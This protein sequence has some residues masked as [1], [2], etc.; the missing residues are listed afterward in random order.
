MGIL[1]RAIVSDDNHVTSLSSDWTDETGAVCSL[2]R[3]DG[4]DSA[5]KTFS[6][7]RVYYTMDSTKIDT[8]VIFRARSCYVNVYINDVLV[9]EDPLVTSPVYGASP[10]SRWHIISLS[11]SDTPVTLCLEV[12]TC[13]TN[14]HGMIDNIY[15]G[16]TRNV[17]QKVVYD[18]IFGFILSNFLWMAGIVILLLYFYMQRRNKAGKDLLYLGF[19]TLFSSQWL[20]AES[21]LWQLFW[22]HSEMIHL[23]GYTALCAIPLSYSALAAYR[24][25]GKMRT[26]AII[27]SAVSTVVL[28]VSTTL[29]LFCILEFHYTL[30]FT[31]I[32]LFFI[33]PLIIPLVQSYTSD[34]DRNSHKIIIL[35]MLGILVVCIAI[36]LIKYFL[37][38]YNDYST[39]VRI[40]LL[41]FLLC[42]IVYQ[43]N[44]VVTTF[45][46]GMK[47]D[48]LHNLALTDHL[49]GLYNRTAFNE[50]TPEYNHIIASFSPLGII[51]FDVNNLKKVNDTLGHEK[52]DQMIKA[53][54]DG[55]NHAFAEYHDICFSYRTGGDEFLTII[56][57]VNADEIYH[58]CI[59]R[60]MSYCE[61]F[62]KQPDLDF[63][64]VIAHG[65]VLTKGNT[66]LSEAI[67][68]ADVLMY[69]NKRQLKALAA[70]QS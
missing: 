23:F 66:T 1:L 3:F 64:L 2:S 17:Y 67:D 35:P 19:A 22:G 54:A 40:A 21:L 47:A 8:A 4:Y 50:H 9:D 38:S 30:V 14:S 56:N 33:I 59:Q 24:L 46:K 58:T 27:Y 49:T 70:N 11:A 68:E 18:K 65:Y 61:E 20:I 32:L 44:Q 62:N 39:Y 42:L 37:G 60:L 53:V 12:T 63:S 7:Q 43:F 15:Y 5:T 10:G 69:E 34:D 51:Q 45:T 41:C 55:L 28:I 29:H 16:N 52:G 31:R 26:F 48:M 6:P 13:Y 36:S 25:K 57:A